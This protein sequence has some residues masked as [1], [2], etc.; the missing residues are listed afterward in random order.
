MG[1]YCHI[2]RRTRANEKFSGKGH[3]KHVCK[4]CSSK[5]GGKVEKEAINESIFDLETLIPFDTAFIQTENIYY[6][7]IWLY[8][9]DFENENGEDERDEELPF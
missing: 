7:D 1:H 2:C 6:D 4:D 9:A 8:E 3:K 5:S